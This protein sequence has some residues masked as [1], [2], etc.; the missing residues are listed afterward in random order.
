MAAYL[1]KEHPLARLATGTLRLMH[2]DLDR[3]ESRPGTTEHAPGIMSTHER[4]T[5]PSLLLA[6]V[7][8]GRDLVRGVEHAS[9]GTTAVDTRGV[10]RP[11][12]VVYLTSARALRLQ[13]NITV[14]LYRLWHVMHDGRVLGGHNCS[15]VIDFERMDGQPDSAKSSPSAA[16]TFP[17]RVE[18]S[19]PAQRSN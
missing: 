6:I 3:Q 18:R 15:S 13:I 14:S 8:A 1:E 2:H 4:R 11:F 19:P 7:D 10:T 12:R 16:I 17:R 9:G 5:Y